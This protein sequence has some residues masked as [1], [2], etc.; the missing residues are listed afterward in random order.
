MSGTFRTSGGESWN[1]IAR[2]TTGN[3]LDADKIRRA[4]PS[5]P[6]PIP[7]GT[8]LQIPQDNLEPDDNVEPAETKIVV[9]GQEFGT[10]DG[11]E[12]GRSVDAIGKASFTVPN[13]PETRAIFRPMSGPTT[14]ISAGPTLLT[15]R[16]ESP[17]AQ[18]TPNSKTL[19]M[20]VY[21]SPG[22][23]ERYNPPIEKFPMEWENG[24]L[25]TIANDLCLPHGIY[26]DFRAAPGPVF[27][28]VDI[29]PGGVVLQFLADLAQQRGPVISS[30]AHGSLLVWEGTQPGNPVARLE[31]GQPGVDIKMEIDETRYYSS[32]TGT[33]PARTKRN[34]SKIKGSG[35]KLTVRNPH[36][37]D[38][39]RPYNVEF[40]DIDPGEIDTAVNA[41]AGRIFSAI[42]SVPVEVATWLDDRG[43]IW[44]P[45]TTIML[46]SPEDYIDDW[47]EFL[48]AD[49]SLKETSDGARS[50]ALR[51]TIPG[52]YTGDIPEVLPWR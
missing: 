16:C 17:A 28:R 20:S 38:E 31:K 25:I 46:K 18:N 5:V 40:E 27:K 47:Y 35:A 44:E 50:A 12:I 41:L 36:A 30:T 34:G 49:V 21:S 9:A 10:W 24:N 45:N 42:V 11:L 32:V 29:Q 26:C 22:I 23:L 3:D 14:V 15:G 1:I 48:I 6:D 52:A 7:A 43:K 51:C 4:N 37:N 13:E 39:V 2:Q 19:T 33:V 8:L